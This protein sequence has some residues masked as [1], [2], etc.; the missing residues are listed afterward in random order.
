[1]SSIRGGAVGA[2]I[3]NRARAPR[4]DRSLG[5]FTL[6]VATLGAPACVLAE[7]PEGYPHVSGELLVQV[8]NDFTFDSDDPDAE[9]NDIYT[10]TELLTEFHFFPAFKLLS[11]LHLESVLDPVNDRF[12]GDEGLY[13][14]ALFLQYDF[15]Y[16]SVL[17][18]SSRR[19]S[20]W[21]GT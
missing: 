2:V 6:V 15:G 10:D 14:E 13:L 21:P 4:S 17:G 19:H 7:K 8:Q 20:V 9:L 11:L 12:F 5:A 16:T 18:G 3:G 1:M